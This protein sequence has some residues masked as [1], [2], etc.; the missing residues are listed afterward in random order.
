MAARNARR[1]LNLVDTRL[2]PA[3]LA[4]LTAEVAS[5]FTVWIPVTPA[6]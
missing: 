1:L 4:A 6:G 2:E 5:V 3:D